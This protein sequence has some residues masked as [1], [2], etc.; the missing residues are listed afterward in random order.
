[1][2]VQDNPLVICRQ[3][4]VWRVLHACALA[5]ALCGMQGLTFKIRLIRLGKT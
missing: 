4:R 1:M 5:R 2:M 3:C